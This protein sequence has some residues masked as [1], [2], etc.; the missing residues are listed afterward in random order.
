MV[1]EREH[2]WM[3]VP[4]GPYYLIGRYYGPTAETQA[5]TGLVCGNKKTFD[6]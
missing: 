1:N 5:I 4:E 3:L 2:V 6:Y